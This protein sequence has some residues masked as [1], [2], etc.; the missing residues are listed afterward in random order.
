MGICRDDATTY[1]RELGYNAVRHPDA[2]LQPL[3]VVGKRGKA[4]QRLGRLHDFVDSSAAEPSL[5]G[6]TAAADSRDERA[7]G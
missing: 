7:A 4:C 6:P 5:E 1:L 3:E 2:T